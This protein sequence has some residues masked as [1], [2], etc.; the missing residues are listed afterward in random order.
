MKSYLIYI[1][2]SDDHE[3][4]HTMMY[5]WNGPIYLHDVKKKKKVIL[6]LE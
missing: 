1:I 6:K 4:R 2:G 3:N 5:L